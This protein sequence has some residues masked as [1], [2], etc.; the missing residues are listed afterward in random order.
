MPWLCTVQ[1]LGH[2]TPEAAVADFIALESATAAVWW[3]FQL[4]LRAVSAAE[5]FALIFG[6]YYIFHC[7]C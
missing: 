2:L 5:R 3:L 1:T 7:H 6:I 4:P